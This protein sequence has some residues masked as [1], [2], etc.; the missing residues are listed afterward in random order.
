MPPDFEGAGIVYRDHKIGEFDD[1]DGDDDAPTETVPLSIDHGTSEFE[2]NDIVD[3]DN[4]ADDDDDDFDD[5]DDG[6]SDYNTLSKHHRQPAYLPQLFLSRPHL[7]VLP[8][9]LLEFLALALTRA[10]LP[11]LLLKRYGS[12][13]Y[14]VMGVA[15]CVRGILAFFACPLFGK[16]SDVWGRRPCLLITRY[17][18]FG[19]GLFLGVLEDTHRY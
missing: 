9:L 4:D 14:I 18:D 6:D 7:A 12:Q 5:D 8:V 19:A 3:N 13:T 11:S 1:N 16:L 15:E 2:D 10:V 17:G